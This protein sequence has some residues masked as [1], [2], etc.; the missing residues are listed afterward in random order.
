MLDKYSTILLDMNDTFMFGADRFGVNEYY[1]IVYQGVIPP[2]YTV[3]IDRLAQRF[4]LGLAI[5]TL[6]LSP[7]F[8][9]R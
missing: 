2:E 1:S 5:P 9:D 6:R 3:A 8:V 4:R 7:S